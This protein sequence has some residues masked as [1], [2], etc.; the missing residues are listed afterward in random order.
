[1]KAHHSERHWRKLNP[2]DKVK[3]A[4]PKNLP[5]EL[6]PNSTCYTQS[7]LKEKL[8][9]N[10]RQAGVHPANGLPVVWL[11]GIFG[12]PGEHF[13]E[14]P[15][16]AAVFKRISK[17]PETASEITRPECVSIPVLLPAT[18]ADTLRDLPLYPRVESLFMVNKPDWLT[19]ICRRW[20]N[21]VSV[22]GMGASHSD[23]QAELC[24]ALAAGSVPRVVAVPLSPVGQDLL[25][26]I[27]GRLGITA[28]AWLQGVLGNLA[29]STVKYR[30]SYLQRERIEDRRRA[31]MA[32]KARIRKLRNLPG[33]ETEDGSSNGNE[34]R[35]RW[36]DWTR[37]GEDWKN[38]DDN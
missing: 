17:A 9:Y 12:Y 27:T 13:G 5:P 35:R 16:Y 15:F 23:T 37:D 31:S 24:S 2:G 1:M 11:S 36:R 34:E 4:P 30:D 25:R 10:I 22:A 19:A 29:R 18:V 8:I 7:F 14:E 33:K 38:E 6:Y 28:E 32:E 3:F 26:E 20:E 21:T